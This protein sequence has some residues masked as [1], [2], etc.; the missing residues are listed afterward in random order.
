MIRVMIA[1]DQVLFNELLGHMLASNEDINIVAKVYDG[2]E[3]LESARILKPDIILMDLSMPILNGI[4]TLRALRKENITSKVLILTS[5]ED[6]EDVNE[7]I[8]IGANGYIMKN[9]SKDRLIL[10]IRSVCAGMDVFDKGVYSKGYN[11]PSRIIRQNHGAIVK[12]HDIMVELSERDITI[13]QLIVQGATNE[14]I[15]KELF[16]A[17]GRIRNIITEIL[18]K[19]ML[20][21]KTQLVVFALKNKLVELR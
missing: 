15:A 11:A 12:V 1:D 3:V 6:S 4:E 7:A 18:S 10:A 8:A 19:L 20:K 16:L 2:H 21:D 17:E 13:I 9:V 5:S 14:E